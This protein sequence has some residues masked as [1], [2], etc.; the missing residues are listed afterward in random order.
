[1]KKTLTTILVFAVIMA[2]MLAVASAIE[3]TLPAQEAM[4]EQTEAPAEAVNG[5]D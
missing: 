3:R 2:A 4:P 5:L 1:M